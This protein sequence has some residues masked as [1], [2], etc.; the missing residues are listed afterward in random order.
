MG[1]SPSGFSGQLCVRLCLPK[2]SL[3]FLPPSSF[4]FSSQDTFLWRIPGFKILDHAEDL[5]SRYLLLAGFVYLF[6]LTNMSEHVFNPDLS[7]Y[8]SEIYQP[9]IVIFYKRLIGE[10]CLFLKNGL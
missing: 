5:H 2:P 1:N 7:V 4:T 10:E 6:P 8:K 3:L 9:S